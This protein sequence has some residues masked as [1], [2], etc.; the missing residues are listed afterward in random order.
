MVILFFRGTHQTRNHSVQLST[1]RAHA[2][3][4]QYMSHGVSWAGS[5]VLSALYE[6]KSGKRKEVMDDR[7]FANMSNMVTDHERQCRGYG[8]VCRCVFDVEGGEDG[9]IDNNPEGTPNGWRGAFMGRGAHPRTRQRH[10][11]KAAALD[12]ACSS[13]DAGD[14]GPPE[15]VFCYFCLVSSVNSRL[16]SNSLCYCLIPHGQHTRA[17]S[18]QAVEPHACSLISS[19][20][21]WEQEG[22]SPASGASHLARAFP[23]VP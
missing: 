3:T 17:S 9:V 19:C 14:C 5:E 15:A 7:S 1:R 16:E 13:W 11:D 2:S 4:T 18:V 22:D 12:P 8:M 21:R 20:A 6:A 23:P 10:E